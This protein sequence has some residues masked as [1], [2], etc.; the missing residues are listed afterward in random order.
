MK[1][2]TIDELPGQTPA[3]HYD[4]IGRTVADDA[5]GVQNFRVGFTRKEYSLTD[6]ASMQAMQHERLTEV[7]TNDHHFRQEGFR[8]PSRT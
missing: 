8:T 4:L 6:C 2:I 7:L 1:F 5:I 3:N